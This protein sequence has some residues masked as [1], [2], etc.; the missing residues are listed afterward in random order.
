MKPESKA[1]SLA[2]PRSAEQLTELVGRVPLK[3]IVSET[4]DLIE[5]LCIETA[6]EHDRRQPRL[7]GAR[8]S[9]CRARACTSSCAATAWSRP[10]AEDGSSRS[11]IDVQP[12]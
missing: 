3:D 7:G 9:A 11:G 10:G 5:Q 2:M 6:L 1:A 8:C 4:T 12:A